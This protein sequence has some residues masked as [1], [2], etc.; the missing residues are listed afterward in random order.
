MGIPVGSPVF[1]SSGN[2]AAANAI[3]T[4]PAVANKTNY[5]TGVEFTGGG[6]TAGVLVVATITG[7]LGGTASYVFAAPTGAT[8]GASLIL[9]FDPPLPASGQNVAIVATLP[10]LGA[11]NTNAVTN[12]RGVLL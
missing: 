9:A 12:A 7:L 10:S 5:L 2:V 3:A 1:N 8:L 4:L 11:G 6:A